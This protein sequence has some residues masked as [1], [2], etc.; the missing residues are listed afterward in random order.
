MPRMRKGRSSGWYDT[1]EY[2]AA[3]L[4]LMA[5]I[6]KVGAPKSDAELSGDE[7]SARSIGKSLR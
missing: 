2:Q 4:P 6:S 3:V 5:Y 7:S 1:I